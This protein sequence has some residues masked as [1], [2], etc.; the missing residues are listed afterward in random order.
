GYDQRLEILGSSGMLLNDNVR[1][2]TI[3]RYTADQ[4]EARPPLLNFFLERYA[5]A[6][7]NEM[8]AFLTALED[9]APMPTGPRDGR[10]ALQ[11]ADAA[12]ESVRTGRPVAV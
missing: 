10:Q 2:S 1:P 11:L 5:E 8:D 7:R 9:G 4:T 12:L 3:R 6:Y